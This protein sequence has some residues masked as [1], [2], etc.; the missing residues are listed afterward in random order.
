MAPRPLAL[1]PGTYTVIAELDGYEAAQV[2]GVVAKLGESTP[3]ALTLTRI[4]GVVRVAVNGAPSAAVRVDDERAQ[5]A[6]TAPCDLQ[7]APGQHELFF[8][9]EGFRAPPRVVNASATTRSAMSA[10]S[11]MMTLRSRLTLPS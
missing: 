4:V 10:M 6:C 11:T 5:P 7:L 2:E 3:V 1:Q 9:A 8:S